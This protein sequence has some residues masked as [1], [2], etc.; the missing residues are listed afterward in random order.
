MMLQLLMILAPLGD[1]PC[2]VE[3]EMRIRYYDI[4]SN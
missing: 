1:G 2:Q 4:L 3:L